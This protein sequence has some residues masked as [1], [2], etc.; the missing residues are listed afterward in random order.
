MPGGERMRLPALLARQAPFAAKFMQQRGPAQRERLSERMREPFRPRDCLLRA[1]QGAVGKS[2]RPQRERQPRQAD[3]TRV[4]NVEIGVQPIAFGV[5][6]GDA[7]LEVLARASEL[8]DVEE[9]RAE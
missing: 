2:Q 9:R 6:E 1:G 4:L 5:V 8:A 3:D 7:A